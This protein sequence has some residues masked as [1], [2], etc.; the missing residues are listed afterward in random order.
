MIPTPPPHIIFDCILFK[1]LFFVFSPLHV[2]PE[3]TSPHPISPTLHTFHTMVSC[4]M[5]ARIGLLLLVHNL[6]LGGIYPLWRNL[7]NKKWMSVVKC[8][9]LHLSDK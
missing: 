3:N 4:D 7:T 6:E 2:L 1:Q 8:P 5:P 9:L